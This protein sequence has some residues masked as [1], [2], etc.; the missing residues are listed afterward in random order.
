[1]SIGTTK[2]EVTTVG[3]PDAETATDGIK[4][5]LLLVEITDV[6]IDRE[7][8]FVVMV[9]F[10]DVVLLLQLVTIDDTVDVVEEVPTTSDNIVGGAD[11]STTFDV[12][13]LLVAILEVG[14]ETD[15]IVE[16]EGLAIV[17]GVEK[18]VVVVAVAGGVVE[19]A[20]SIV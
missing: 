5:A 6:L 16:F 1:M 13:T 15:V 8:E 11:E 3:T 4:A 14:V 18:V 12:V 20:G 9:L 2:S 17:E 19:A 10:A 7:E